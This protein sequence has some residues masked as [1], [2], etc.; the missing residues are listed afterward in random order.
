MGYIVSGFPNL[1]NLH[2][3]VQI[4]H[5]MCSSRLAWSLGSHV[6]LSRK[7]CNLGLEVQK[8]WT[9]P[10]VMTIQLKSYIN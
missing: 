3:S 9:C 10:P 4:R 6:T 7:P 2:F 5:K 1:G 8:V